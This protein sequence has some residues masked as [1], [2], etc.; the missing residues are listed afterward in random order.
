LEGHEQLVHRLLVDAWAGVLDAETR[1]FGARRYNGD[2]HLTA[3]VVVLDRVG[4][5]VDQDL[6]EPLL[7]GDHVTAS[8]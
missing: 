7:V 1:A 8:G 3:R 5:Q 2:A 4:E 6:F